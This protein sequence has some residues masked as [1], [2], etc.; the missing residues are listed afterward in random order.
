[1]I[2]IKMIALYHTWAGDFHDSMHNIFMLSFFA[3]IETHNSQFD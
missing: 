1:M 2:K 3:A